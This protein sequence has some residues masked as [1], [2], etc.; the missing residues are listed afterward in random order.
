MAKRFKISREDQDAFALR[1][2]QNAAAARRKGHFA[3][4]IVTVGGVSSDDGKFA[5]K[6]VHVYYPPG[7]L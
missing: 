4:E 1:S 6:Y 5:Y 2:H 7:F 3:E